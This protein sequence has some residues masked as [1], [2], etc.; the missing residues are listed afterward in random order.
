MN[1]AEKAYPVV[2]GLQYMEGGE[3]RER[4]RGDEISSRDPENWNSTEQPHQV[5]LGQV[6][7]LEWHRTTCGFIRPSL[8]TSW[9]TEDF[10]LSTGAGIVEL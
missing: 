2:A 4:D 7:A 9:A 3:Q 5:L 8:V 1:V 10:R 6:S